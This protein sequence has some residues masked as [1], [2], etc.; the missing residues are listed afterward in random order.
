M[1]L[2]YGEPVRTVAYFSPEF[3]V[4][5]DLPQYS[6]GLGVLAGDHLK[7]AADMGL[8]LVGVGLFYDHGYFHQKL[9]ESGWQR[10][11]FPRQDP[12]SMPVSRVDARVRLELAGESVEAAVCR[13]E[14][15]SVPLYL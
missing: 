15:G 3:G 11:E 13:H 5:E 7:G 1:L 6:G 10:E 2:P 4:S 12:G 8:P 9:D 14:V